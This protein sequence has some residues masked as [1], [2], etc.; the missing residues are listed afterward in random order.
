[1]ATVLPV[2]LVIDESDAMRACG[3][4]LTA[5]LAALRDRLRSDPAMASLRLTVL[6]M[7]ESTRVHLEADAASDTQHPV[8]GGQANYAAAFADLLARIPADTAWLEGSGQRVQRPLVFFLAGGQPDPNPAAPLWQLRQQLTDQRVTPAAPVIVAC[9]HPSRPGLTSH[10]AWAA[11]VLATHPNFAFSAAPGTS[12]GAAVTAF[13]GAL[14]ENLAATAALVGSPVPQI[15]AAAP[16][17]FTPVL[18]PPPSAF[19]TPVGPPPAGVFP[20]PAPP[21]SRS[22]SRLRS[23]RGLAISAIGAVAVAALVAGVL[24][25]VNGG[26]PVPLAAQPQAK[27]FT[28]ALA[29]LAAEPMAHYQAT[30]SGVG[31]ADVYVTPND[32]MIG[33]VTQDGDTINV[34]VADGTEYVKLPSSDLP[35]SDN[36]V[37]EKVMAGKWLSGS[38]VTSLAGNI[39]PDF[40]TPL[41]LAATLASEL[42]AGTD[43]GNAT[44]SPTAT[45]TAT[46]PP[47]G[48]QGTMLDG[49]PVLKATMPSGDIYVTKNQP[50]RVVSVAP[51]AHTAA[52]STSTAPSA[53][54]FVRPDAGTGTVQLL[55]ETAGDVASE[56]QT[57]ENDTKQLSQADDT[58]L[59]FNLQGK[60]NVSCGSGGCTAS[61]TVTSDGSDFADT[62]GDVTGYMAASLS[63]DGKP[64]GTCSSTGSLPVNGT[65]TISCS[66]PGAGSVFDSVKSQ[67]AG[68]A[69][70]QSEDE[71]GAEVSYEV[72]YEAETYTYAAPQVNASGLVSEEQTEDDAGQGAKTPPLT[73]AQ[74]ADL[75]RYLGYHP[76]SSTAGGG[77][78][79]FTNGTT[80]IS[81][82]SA[83]PA[84]GTWRI[85]SS[86][87]GLQST[88]SRTA[89]TDA[90][91]TEV[92]GP[93]GISA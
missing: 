31:L 34:L 29:A 44:P 20:V 80:F 70:Q 62:S 75:A 73:N 92:A 61:A 63:I 85:A 66:D 14:G 52:G 64:A 81:P 21:G 19:P 77:Q 2:Y 55:Q 65:G 22:R 93:G 4:E 27:P 72:P 17:G 71:G 86:A 82:D 67:K 59:S 1:M 84:G 45:A 56:Y 39:Q 88:S 5:G 60:A 51:R 11:Q 26:Q 15:V 40:Q 9:A 47:A 90:L 89:T 53:D 28:A 12:P 24:V 42:S 87:Q 79:V 46:M 7:A 36:P 16:P 32:E 57:L 6:G 3:D 58:D 8:P 33:T 35:D 83:S 43:P 38:L 74:A 10:A 25:A 69:L 48:S 37:E 50:Y 13:F 76:T 78:Q 41:S 30:I 49:V 68:A 23:R 54:A 91:L 18:P